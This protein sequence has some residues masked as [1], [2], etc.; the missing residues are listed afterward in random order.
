MSD[1]LEDAANKALEKEQNRKERAALQRKLKTKYPAARTKHIKFLV[2]WIATGC[3]PW[4]AYKKV[5][6]DHILESSARS[7]ASEIL[8]KTGIE[9]IRTI[10]DNSGHGLTRL[11]EALDKLFD[12]DPKEYLKYI[13]KYLQLDT[14][15]IEHSG[16]INI[17]QITFT[18]E[19]DDKD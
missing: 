17:P 15:K 11:T 10:L 5:Y 14:Q 18:S 1:E 19:I 6:G 3:Y 13:T 9:D 12:K 2:E 16:S 7:S 4:Q 8:T